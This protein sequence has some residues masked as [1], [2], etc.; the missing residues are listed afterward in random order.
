MLRLLTAVI[1]TIF[2]IS[3]IITLLQ[4]I[5]G[6]RLPIIQV[7]I[8][9]LQWYFATVLLLQVLLM[10]CKTR[11]QHPGLLALQTVPLVLNMGCACRVA[12]LRTWS[13]LQLSLH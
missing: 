3:G 12:P 1:G 10:C 9:P 4:T 5:V 6:D 11:F 2:F 8:F 7:Q 13:L